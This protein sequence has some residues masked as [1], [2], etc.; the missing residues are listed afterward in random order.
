L[1]NKER[2]IETMKDANGQEHEPAGSGSGSGRA[3]SGESV[4][5][6][7]EKQAFI[8]YTKNHEAI[9]AAL[10]SSKSKPKP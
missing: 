10:T 3:A 1:L 2:R 5:T 9:N 4:F 6:A 7:E 8:D